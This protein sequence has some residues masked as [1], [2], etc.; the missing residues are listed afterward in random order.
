MKTPPE[1]HRITEGMS[2]REKRV[3]KKFHDG[4]IPDYDDVGY[5]IGVIDT[6]RWD[7]KLLRDRIGAAYATTT[8]ALAEPPDQGSGTLIEIAS[9]LEM[10][11][12]CPPH[13][14]PTDKTRC[15]ECPSRQVTE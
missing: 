13:G 15:V 9:A 10:C 12:D 3:C 11:S 8:R 5:L 4:V 7:R 6:I 1:L 2:D 14:Y